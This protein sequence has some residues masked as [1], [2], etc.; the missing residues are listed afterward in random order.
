ME[1]FPANNLTEDE[2]LAAEKAKVWKS[3]RER[4]AKRHA[5]LCSKATGELVDFLGPTSK[6]DWPLLAEY[7]VSGG[8]AQWLIPR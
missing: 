4:H 8:K 1:K 5:I 7:L 6:E 3:V 2:C